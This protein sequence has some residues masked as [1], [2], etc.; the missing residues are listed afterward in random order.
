MKARRKILLCGPLALVAVSLPAAATWIPPDEEV[1]VE[2]LI[3]NSKSAVEKNPDDSD[4]LYTLGRVCSLRYSTGATRC[5]VYTDG[6][7]WRP[8]RYEVRSSDSL[9]ANMGELPQERLGYLAESIRYYRAATG[10]KPDDPYYW[11]GLGY[12]YGQAA[13]HAEQMTW[14]FDESS[15]DKEAKAN[16]KK[17]RFWEDLALEAYRK[18]FAL[19]TER[20]HDVDVPVAAEAGQGILTILGR[21][22]KLTKDEHREFRRTK[23][24]VSSMTS[25]PRPITPIVFSLQ[26][27]PIER[28]L[29]EEAQVPFDLDGTGRD[30]RWSWLK[31]GTALLAWDP[32]GTGNIRSG[33]QLFGNVTWWMF[34]RNG[35]AALAALDDD[36]NTWLEGKELDGIAVWLDQNANACSEPGEVLP[37]RA[38]GI[39]GINT[40][41]TGVRMDMPYCSSGIRF[42]NGSTAATYDWIAQGTMAR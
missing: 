28:L 41:V 33:R 23:R 20:K 15:F 35:Y 1:P 18:S 31:P 32:R 21:R 34:W 3:D 7:F 37:V 8:G 26:N 30:I 6:A 17:K 22:E 5:K 9:A 25:G 11:L 36:A 16:E 19:D 40:R 24:A 13:A 27:R 42:A 12:V 10:K 14:P 29:D 38:A 2:R 4:A 39:T